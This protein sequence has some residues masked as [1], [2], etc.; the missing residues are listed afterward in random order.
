MAD[1]KDPRPSPTASAADPCVIYDNAVSFNEVVNGA[2]TVTTYTGKELLTLSQAIDK[3]GFGVAPFTFAVGGT[4]DSLNLLVS[5]SPT[6]GFLYKYVGA[7]SAPITVTDGTDPT[8]SADW[9]AF[10]ATTL[11]SLGGLASP[12]DLAQRHRIKTTVAEVATGVFNDGDRLELSDRANAKFKVQLGG[13]AD[14]GGVI[15]AG[16]GKTAILTEDKI[17]IEYFGAQQTPAVS[18]SSIQAAYNYLALKSKI[19]LNSFGGDFTFSGITSGKAVTINANGAIFRN[20]VDG[21]KMFDYQYSG[22]GDIDKRVFM[23][24]N[25]ARFVDTTTGTGTGFYS[26]LF[27]FVEVNRCFFEKFKNN[28]GLDIR[29]T[30]WIEINNTNTDSSNINLTSVLNPHF[31]NAIRINGGELRNPTTRALSIINCDVLTIETTIEGDLSNTTSPDYPVYLENVN[32]IDLKVYMEFLRTCSSGIY[33]KNVRY[34]VIKRS[35]INT[36]NDNVPALTMENC[37]QLEINESKLASPFKTV[38]TLSSVTVNKCGIRGRMDIREGH[39]V[40]F[41]D[42]GPLD[43]AGAFAIN[44]AYQPENYAGKGYP[45]KNWYTSSSFG[46]RDPT[47]DI[48]VS[49]T[50]T[51]IYDATQGYHDNN[52]LKVN[53]TGA[54]TLVFQ[55]MGTT[56]AAN[57][58]AVISFMAKSTVKTNINAQGS[59]VSTL[60]TAFC[61]FTPEWKRFF[62]FTQLSAGGLGV[63]INVIL[64]STETC[65]YLIDDIQTAAYSTFDEA[66]L[67]VA[68]WRHVPTYGTKIT[69]KVSDQIEQHKV[70]FQ[71]GI[72]MRVYALAP[73]SPQSGDW[74]MANGTT[75]NPLASSG[76]AYPVRWTGS[77]WR[78]FHETDNG[79]NL[80]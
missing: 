25:D 11:Q 8:I 38:G 71:H 52:S 22:V 1:Y 79:T 6:D 34:G 58:G 23:S 28:N 17:Y 10:A 21:A 4:L 9:Q 62:I 49:S 33:C 59:I 77:A 14:G 66:R 72:N 35:L 29:E 78:G 5:N 16:P 68:N 44:P 27:F 63:G 3:F 54:Q 47:V 64:T 51:Y 40:K 73:I 32:M 57:Q 20:A 2:A 65:E 31:N 70:W 76:G 53:C 19:V 75:W 48:S 50:S 26:N 39:D 12:S 43:T 37:G 36:N 18:S 55:N 61:T 80:I 69:E 60:G 30:L 56:D 67:I 13:A 46:E 42:C 7:G 74:F 45:L 41:K 15:S 24:V